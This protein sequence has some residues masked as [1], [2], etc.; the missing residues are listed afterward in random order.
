MAKKSKNQK[1]PEPMHDRAMVTVPLDDLLAIH[2]QLLMTKPSGEMILI[3]ANMI[4]TLRQ[5][6]NTPANEDQ[7]SNAE[8]PPAEPGGEED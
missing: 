4:A 2:N 7:P 8:E 5:L 3:T 6:M 1:R